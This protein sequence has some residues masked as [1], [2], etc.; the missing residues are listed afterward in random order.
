MKVFI[1]STAYDL[2]DFREKIK[3]IIVDLGHEFIAHESPDFPIRQNLHSHDQCIEAVKD[4]DLVICI[5]DRRYGGKYAGNFLTQFQDISLSVSGNTPSGKNKKYQ[6]TILIKDLSITWCELITAQN[7]NKE[8]FT[9]ARQ[10]L[11]DE[12]NVRRRNQ[13]LKSFKPFY[14]EKEELYD[15]IDWITKSRIN[16]WITSFDSIVD[17]E[18]YFRKWLIE[19]NKTRYTPS[20]IPTTNTIVNPTTVLFILEGETDRDFISIVIQKLKLNIEAKFVVTYGK[21]RLLNNLMDYV[22]NTGDIEVFFILYDVDQDSNNKTSEYNQIITKSI[23]K[24]PVEI[25]PIE[26]EIESWINAG[27]KSTK[28]KL[29]KVSL[30]I[31]FDVNLAIKN[32]HPFKLFIDKLKYYEAK[33]HRTTAS[34]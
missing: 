22:I 6:K 1:S 25:F 11:L 14:A 7:S 33:E 31:E 13:F 34:T 23:E 21:Y 19:A 10:K 9:F 28:T 24:V 32:N 2:Y 30:E 18:K 8:I 12:K 29:K 16:N 5:L 15:L 26:P 4:A 3:Q 20:V 17:F 27:L